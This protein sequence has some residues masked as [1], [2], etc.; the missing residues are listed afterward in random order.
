M[1]RRPRLPKRIGPYTILER[2]AVGQIAEVYVARLGAEPI[3]CLKRIRS[4]VLDKPELVEAFE[5]EMELA[6]RFRHPNIVEIYDQGDDGGRYFVMELIDGCDLQTLLDR[7][8]PLTSGLVAHLGVGLARALIHI[9]HT[10]RETGRRPVVHCDV[11]PSNVLVRRDGVVK[12]SDFG[13]AKV[14]PNTGAEALTRRRGRP[15]YASPEQ[16][17]GEPLSARTDLFG[18]GLVLW[19]ALIGTHPYAEGRPPGGGMLNVW[20]QQRTIANDRRSLAEAAPHAPPALQ[21]AIE[22]LLQPVAERTATAEELLDA[23]A[24]LAPLHGDA[25][26]ASLVAGAKPGAPR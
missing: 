13:V 7:T 23:L 17:L 4:D 12:L 24:P 25:E 10:D 21:D 26:L 20:I 18:A 11:S 16:W 9:H 14:L 6:R 1:T 19:R 15:R 2:I 3:V 22:R 5:Q 8:G